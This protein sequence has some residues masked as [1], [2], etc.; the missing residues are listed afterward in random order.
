MVQA[1]KI[2]VS[3]KVQGVYFR[4]SAQHTAIEIGIKGWVRNE[5][6][7]SVLIHAEGTEDQPRAFTKWCHRGPSAA[8]VDRCTCHSGLMEHCIS[9]T[10]LR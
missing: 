1:H 6:N 8:T 3:G 10:I 4:A 7:G 5:P 9:F 2:V